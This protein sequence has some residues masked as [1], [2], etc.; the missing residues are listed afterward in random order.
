MFSKYLEGLT[1][2]MPDEFHKLAQVFELN[3]FQPIMIDGEKDI[4]AAYL[5]NDAVES[6]FV[7]EN[8]VMTGVYKDIECEQIAGIDR[9]MM[10]IC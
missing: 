6:Y 4:H 7:F 10:I 2:D 9:V 1:D 3:V 5:M 8:S